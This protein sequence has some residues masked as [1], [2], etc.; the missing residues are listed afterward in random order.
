VE[1]VDPL[2]E[3]VP[4]RLAYVLAG[5]EERRGGQAVERWLT[6]LVRGPLPGA[7]VLFAVAV[8]LANHG[9]GPLGL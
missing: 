6:D 7:P 3:C 4:A 8:V 2:G 5:Q 1:A 9:R